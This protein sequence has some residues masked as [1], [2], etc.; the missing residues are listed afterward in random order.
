MVAPELQRA[1]LWKSHL[2]QAESVHCSPAPGAPVSLVAPETR[3]NAWPEASHERRCAE[4]LAPDRC[5]T[6]MSRADPHWEHKAF[7]MI[8]AAP[9]PGGRPRMACLRRATADSTQ[10]A[11][12]RVVQFPDCDPRHHGQQSVQGTRKN[13][14]VWAMPTRQMWT[15]N[16]HGASRSAPAS[17][18][19]PSQRRE[20]A[21]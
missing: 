2:F 21:M 3:P 20:D 11:G 14:A 19:A 13:Q 16:P 7:S 18:G 5:L 15:S 1:L 10:A 17:S 4:W 12:S 8:L 6:Y 9:P